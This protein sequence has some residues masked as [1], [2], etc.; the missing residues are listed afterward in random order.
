[1]AADRY[2]E[3]QEPHLA[4]RSIVTARE[5]LKPLK[6]F[7]G[8]TVLKRVT[9]ESVREYIVRRKKM[10]LSNRTVNMEVGW[11]ARLLKRAKRWHLIADEIKPLPERRNQ[12]RA[13]SREE[14]IRLVTFRARC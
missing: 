9:A 14:K 4:P 6:E 12:G 7:F 1:M 10:R 13:L 5:R 2:L 8:A 3:D 11:L